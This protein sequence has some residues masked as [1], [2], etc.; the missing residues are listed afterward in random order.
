MIILVVNQDW[1]DIAYYCENC[2]LACIEYGLDQEGKYKWY[3][4]KGK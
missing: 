4:H 2:G 1:D 3:T